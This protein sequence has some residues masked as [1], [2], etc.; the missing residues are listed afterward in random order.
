[1]AEMTLIINNTIMAK[2]TLIV[3]ITIMAEITL[4][5]NI[6]IMTKIINASFLAIENS[7]RIYCVSSFLASELA[8]FR[9][10]PIADGLP[11]F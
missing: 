8:E 9:L 3:T 7:L 10:Q 2:I 1:M 5:K 11:R 4:I 6:T